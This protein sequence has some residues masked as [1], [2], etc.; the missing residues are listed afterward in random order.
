MANA[1]KKKNKKGK[2]SRQPFDGVFN[3]LDGDNK[4]SWGSCKKNIKV[5]AIT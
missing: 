3:L 5:L 1:N 4:H 2:R